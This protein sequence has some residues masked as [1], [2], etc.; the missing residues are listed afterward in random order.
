[1]NKQDFVQGKFNAAWDAVVNQA[2][3]VQAAALL[4]SPRDL[5]SM[6]V[7]AARENDFMAGGCPNCP[8]RK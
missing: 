7:L 8:V 2:D 5:M 6:D 4:T 1:M 3:A